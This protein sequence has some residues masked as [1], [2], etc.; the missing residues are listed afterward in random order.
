MSAWFGLIW[1]DCDSD[2]RT[3]A[4]LNPAGGRRL[5]AVDHFLVVQRHVMMMLDHMTKLLGID[6]TTKPGD[7]DMC[8]PSLPRSVDRIY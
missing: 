4:Y 1:S 2:S 6:T 7:G 3:W 5:A 8:F